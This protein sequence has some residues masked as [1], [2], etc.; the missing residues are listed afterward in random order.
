M[1]HAKTQIVS[2]SRR[3][4]VAAAVVSYQVGHAGVDRLL[5]QYAHIKLDPWW[6]EVGQELQRKA[7]KKLEIPSPKPVS[8]EFNRASVC[9]PSAAA[10]VVFAVMWL[11][12]A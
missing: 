1:R 4:R 9:V 6:E 5:K 11:R 8:I 10:G 7:V 2:F 12:F 3:A